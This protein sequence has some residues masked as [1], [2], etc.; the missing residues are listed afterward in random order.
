MK[1]PDAE[2]TL[3]IAFGLVLVAS[4]VSSPLFQVAFVI[5]H[6]VGGRWGPGVTVMVVVLVTPNQL[7]VIV[8]LVA[9]VTVEVARLKV[10]VA[11]LALTTVSCGTR[12]MAGWLLDS[13]TTAPWVIGAVNRTVPVAF[14][15]PTI[16]VGTKDT[17]DSEGP[18]G[19]AALTD[20]MWVRE[21]L[22]GVAPMICTISRRA[23]AF[24]VI[25]KVPVVCPAGMVI[26]T[27]TW[28]TDGVAGEQAH[29]RRP[30]VWETEVD[31]ARRRLRPRAPSPG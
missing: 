26:D 9:V 5:L 7:A 15:P 22:S 1:L 17:D 10:L 24:E 11:V 30:G 14:W 6:D 12:A 23:A 8:T 20:R 28:A 16:D 3:R 25:V 21:M 29:D 18:A 13:C 31:G 19:V 4:I 2:K 27:G